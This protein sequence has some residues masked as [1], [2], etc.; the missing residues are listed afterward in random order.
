VPLSREDREGGLQDAPPT[1]A[2]EAAGLA[3]HEVVEDLDPQELACGRE[4]TRQD[5][6]L[7]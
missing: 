5:Y 7:G 1:Q 6:V 3:D 4:A 2:H